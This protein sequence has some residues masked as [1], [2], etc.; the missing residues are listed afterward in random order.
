MNFN[1]AKKRMIK[2]LESDA[3]KNREDA[4]TTLKSIKILQKINQLGFITNDSQEGVIETGTISESPSPKKRKKYVIK[5]RAYVT[6]FMKRN[7]SKEFVDRMNSLTDKIAFIIDINKNTDNY[8]AVT[9]QNN[10]PFTKIFLN[11]NIKTFNFIKSEAY[12]DKDE[13]VDCVA[14]IDPVYGRLATSKDGLYKDIIK[15]LSY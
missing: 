11:L 14:C 7:Q 8:I 2:Y 13:E 5:E 4:Q 1:N 12:L 15:S 9:T 10:V 6:G 3:F